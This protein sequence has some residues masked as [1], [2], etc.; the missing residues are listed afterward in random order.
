MAGSERK[1]SSQIAEVAVAI[2]LNRALNGLFGHARHDEQSLL[3][4]V[5]ALLKFDACHPN[6]PV[7]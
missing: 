7:M 5:E 2:G 6:L 4:F 3:E 1:T